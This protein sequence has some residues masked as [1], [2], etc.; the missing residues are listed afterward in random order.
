MPA[1]VTLER[2]GHV[3]VVTI[4]RPEAMNAVNAAVAGGIGEALAEADADDSVRALVITGTGAAFCAG[5]DLKAL[6]RREDISAPGHPEWGFAGYTRHF[7]S[8][9]TI[10]AVNG[11]AL[12]GGTEIVLASDL[13]VLD[14]G[15]ALGL[16]EVKRGLL[17]AAG[18]VIRTQRQIPLKLAMELA[19]TGDPVDAETAVRW[20][21]ANRAA[22]SGKALETAV[23]LAERIAANAPLSVR[24]TKKT[25]HRTAA[26]G[27][28][29]D[30]AP[31]EVNDRAM[32]RVLRSA[33]F[34]EGTRAFAE[35]RAPQWTGR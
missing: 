28:D 4:R 6:A 13:A 8:V 32:G 31:W 27:S 25:M 7:V 34:A 9:P 21:L 23:E 11:F 33:D 14:E 2:H 18:G 16:P 29:W 19:L 22:P 30:E 26:L 5:A 24:E 15:A 20:G 12:G 3:G 35:K 1:T 17:A 10:A